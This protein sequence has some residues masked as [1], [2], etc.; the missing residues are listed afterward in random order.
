MFYGHLLYVSED[1]SYKDTY[2]VS[3]IYKEI[4]QRLFDCLRH[5]EHKLI[6]HKLHKAIMLIKKTNKQMAA[7][8][9]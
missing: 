4:K 6:Q 2:C 8:M 3:E 7:I 9:K 5:R 1:M